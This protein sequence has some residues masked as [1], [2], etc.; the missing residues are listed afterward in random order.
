MPLDPDRNPMSNFQNLVNRGSTPVTNTILALNVATAVVGFFAPPIAA[1][2][3]AFVALTPLAAIFMP[4]TLVTYPF[5]NFLP[6][7]DPNA[8]FNLVICAFFFWV[9]GGSLERSWGSRNYFWFFAILGI[10]SG[11]SV[12]LG[13]GILNHFGRL[14]DD[15]SVYGFFLPLVATIVAFCTINPEQ[16]MMAFF[17]P[18]KAKYIAIIAVA[19]AWITF[20]ASLGLFACGGSLAAYL[21]V[22][23][24]RPWAADGYSRK[25]PSRGEIIDFKAARKR[26]SN[27]VYLDGSIRRSPLD[28]AGRWRD[29][30]EKKKLARLL[31]NSG[32]IDPDD[33][34]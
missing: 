17:I 22:R 31:K 11:L 4:W 19:A 33:R 13:A 7:H 29:M 2:L 25:A 32:L 26:K 3:M 28:F 14:D 24:G 27:A 15:R 34:R 1:I 6:Q 9:S 30:Q 21:W 12:A 5:V 18:L 23:N 8:L 16:Q 10:V 20:G